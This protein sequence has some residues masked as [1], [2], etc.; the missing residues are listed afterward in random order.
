[1]ILLDGLATGSTAPSDTCELLSGAGLLEC[2]TPLSHAGA[3][4][5][6]NESSDPIA[7]GVGNYVAPPNTVRFVGDPR[8]NEVFSAGPPGSGS[9][10]VMHRVFDNP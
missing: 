1:M 8:A 10:V 6:I 9:P 2:G 3:L 7:G 5:S 4:V